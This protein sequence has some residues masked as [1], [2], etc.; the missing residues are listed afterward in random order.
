M[1]FNYKAIPRILKSKEIKEE[2][3]DILVGPKT[4]VPISTKKDDQINLQN[5]FTNHIEAL[6]YLGELFVITDDGKIPTEI[7]KREMEE[8]IH[9]HLEYI[10]SLFFKIISSKDI[11]EKYGSLKKDVKLQA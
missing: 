2:L 3:L 7:K 1:K 6:L 8:F 10:R 11:H 4:F 5:L 9:E